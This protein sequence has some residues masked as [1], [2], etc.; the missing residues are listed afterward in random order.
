VND[1][2]GCRADGDITERTRDAGQ[3][4]ILVVM[5]AAVLLV[6]V[7]GAIAT[8][9]RT[10]LHRARAQTAADAAA[11]A[12]VGGDI[13]DA[14]RLAD[15]HGA[16][17]VSWARGPGPDEVTVIVSVSGVRAVARASNHVPTPP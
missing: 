14:R 4:A 11:L 15:A 12:S 1:T 17:V 13:D 16:T 9:G 10:T 6:A 5:V 3:A 7:M 8:M 2:D